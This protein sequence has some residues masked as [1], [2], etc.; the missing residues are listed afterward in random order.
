MSIRGLSSEE[1]YRSYFASRNL[2]P[3]VP[4]RLG[5]DWRLTVEAVYTLLSVTLL[6]D[7]GLPK[8]AR[9]KHHPGPATIAVPV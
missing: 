4:A 3:T 8:H 1:V 6:T 9:A 2:L 5:N 7:E